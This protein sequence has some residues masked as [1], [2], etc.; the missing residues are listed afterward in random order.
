MKDET[1]IGSV[2]GPA[3]CKYNIPLTYPDRGIGGRKDHQY[4]GRPVLDKACGC[5]PLLHEDR[6]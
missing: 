1:D 3:S 5:E 4:R 6:R 2:F